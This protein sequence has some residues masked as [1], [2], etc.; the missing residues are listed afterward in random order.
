MKAS[1]ELRAEALKRAESIVDACQSAGVALDGDN[2]DRFN[3]EVAAAE[4]YAIAQ[5]ADVARAPYAVA[6]AP[7][8]TGGSDLGAWLRQELRVV[9][10]ESDPGASLDVTKFH[11]APIAAL[12][13]K[14]VFLS[15][16]VQ[17]IVLKDAQSLTV[18][19]YVSNATAA[20]VSAGGSISPTDSDVETQI[21]TPK[22]YKVRSRVSNE[23]LEDLTTVAYQSYADSL[24]RGLSTALDHAFFQ[25]VGTAGEIRGLKNVSGIQ[26]A[27][28]A[29]QGAIPTDLD[30]VQAAFYALAAENAVCTAIV[31]HPR[32]WATLSGI[33]T[34]T[35][36]SEYL[37]GVNSTGVAGAQS[38]SLFGVPVFTSN[39]LSIVETAGTAG[40]SCSSA[41]F[42]DAKE[43]LTVWR[44]A[45][46]VGD[47]AIRLD[48]VRNGVDYSTD[49]IV[50]ARV[51]LLVPHVKSVY[52]A[53]GIKA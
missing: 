21:A 39:T 43:L 41:Y 49:L 22:S 50:S 32:T 13:P 24:V 11:S 42:F 25:G 16:G 44:S 45:G 10:P 14:S 53:S 5:R 34:I 47:S 26:G 20:A 30:W 51:D 35:G 36:S 29:A 15:T 40:T 6:I 37:I 3:A 9:V 52:R 38:M 28:I 33:R 48:A 27:A 17:T 1:K 4:G 19:V 2:L 31:M 46:G 8:A 12:V 23:V 18:P 7:R